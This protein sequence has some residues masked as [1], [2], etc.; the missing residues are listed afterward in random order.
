[1]HRI[2]AEP[3]SL[4]CPSPVL[5][6]SQSRHLKVLRLKDG[7]K[8]EL[9]DGKG[10]CRRYEYR[11]KALV[12]VS[13]IAR[14]PARR[15]KISLFA[16]ITKGSRWDWTVEKAVELGADRIVPVISE[17]T[18]VRIPAAERASKRERF[19]RIAE[20]AARQ[21]GSLFIPEISEICNFAEALEM[22]KTSICFTGALTTPPSALFIDELEKTVL[23]D[24]GDIAL[25]VGPEGDFTPAELSSLIAVTTPVSFG[26]A[27]L[28]SETAAVYALSILSA[29]RS[30]KR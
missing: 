25:F 29:V 7:E 12:A 4:E 18:I 10:A 9:F 17:R 24:E 15:L 8:V 13:E 22:A 1:M 30:R 27:V 2:P 21:C 6:A 20:D 14:E 28:R 11:N 23:P 19:A 26:D 16:C 3:S 5:T